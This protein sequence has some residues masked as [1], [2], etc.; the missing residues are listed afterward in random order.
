MHIS[1]VNQRAIIKITQ[2]Q[3][4]WNTVRQTTLKVAH[5]CAPAPS[6]LKRRMKTASWGCHWIDTREFRKLRRLLQRKRHTEIVFC[7]YSTSITLDKIGQMSLIGTNGSHVRG[8]EWNTYC[9]GLAL[10]SEPQI[11][12]LHDIEWL[13]HKIAPN[14]VRH[15]QHDYFSSFNQS[16]LDLWRS[17]CRCCHS[18]H[19]FNSLKTT[20][21]N[22][23][24]D[25][26]YN[27]KSISSNE[28]V[29]LPLL[30]CRVRSG[31]EQSSW[32]A[33][34]ATCSM[35]VFLPPLTD[36]YHFL[37]SFLLLSLSLLS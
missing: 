23:S 25:G 30:F 24:H 27:K 29:A 12:K 11:W 34:I 5:P 32:N 4:H 1:D 33:R 18:H 16:N 35:Y 21:G 7:D 31:N 17:R 19:F 36:W 10:S 22:R 6:L 8:K 2:R 9:C 14:S 28:Y 15:L 26:G 3:G 20:I 37:R 13:R